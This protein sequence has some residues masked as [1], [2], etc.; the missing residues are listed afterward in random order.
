MSRLGR[1]F[2]NNAL[3]A[4]PPRII[5]VT[6]TAVG[7]GK[8]GG[9]SPVSFS[10]SIPSSANCSLIWVAHYSTSTT[11]II[12]AQIGS[13]PATLQ[14]TVNPFQTS[15]LSCFAL[16][17]P[18]TSSQTITFTSN[19]LY[20]GNIVINTVHYSNVVSIGAATGVSNQTGQPSM[21]LASV[22]K[23]IYV[24]G[25]SYGGNTG[26][27]FNSYSQNQ[28]YVAAASATNEP[29]LFGDAAGNGGTLTFSATRSTTTYSWGGI[30]ISLSPT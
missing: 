21:A 6:Y 24:N 5:S 1:G 10:D 25:F 22:P 16:L 11:P 2:P 3:R 20:N 7:S 29:L 28:R 14:Q 26:N 15:L 12:S 27:T 18:P 30:V 9:T 17:N 8:I 19:G 23:S 4:I 13:T